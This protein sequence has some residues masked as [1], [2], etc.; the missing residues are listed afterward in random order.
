MRRML[1]L[2]IALSL[3][4]DIGAE[5]PKRSGIGMPVR[6]EQVVLPGSELEI[7]PGGRKDAVVMRIVASYPHGTAFR[8]DLEY[9]GL[10]PGTFD[11]RQYLRRKDGSS[12]ADLPSLAV[13]FEPHLPAGQ[14]APSEPPPRESP[15]LGGYRL[16][17]WIAGILWCG[18]LATILL[19]NRRPTSAAHTAEARPL[20]LA[21]RLR[22][23]VQK[24]RAGEL[25]APQRA[26]LERTLLAYWQTRLN[27]GQLR[28]VEAFAELRRHPDAGPLLAALE[29]WLHRPASGH[30][31]DVGQLLE[32]YRD[33]PAD[34]A[35]APLAGKV[36]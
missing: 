35:M 24:A 13:T 23:L 36:S 18:G 15:W 5:E 19:W 16:V 10:D 20:S 2:C 7:V 27:L 26:E 6:W 34:E 30:D 4:A 3:A 22:P 31:V 25:T 8:Y 9:Y 12:T 1:P 32:P 14:F 33:L 21:E 28:P 17:L 29:S 11:L